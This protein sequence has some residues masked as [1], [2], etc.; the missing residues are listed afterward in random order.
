MFEIYA[1]D[2]VWDWAFT[3]KLAFRIGLSLI[4]IGLLLINWVLVRK[5][6]T[7]EGCLVR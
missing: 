5:V 6:L 1:H 3:N 2:L 4:G 7:H